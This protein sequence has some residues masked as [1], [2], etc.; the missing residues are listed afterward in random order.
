MYI[1]VKNF[2]FSKD[3]TMTIQV[4]AGDEIDVPARFV[5][6]LLEAG[7]ISG[8]PVKEELSNKAASPPPAIKEA[9][10]EIEIP[11]ILPRHKKRRN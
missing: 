11:E 7:L 8:D 1:V 6:G 4:K 3:G 5:L 10:E 9:A 2:P